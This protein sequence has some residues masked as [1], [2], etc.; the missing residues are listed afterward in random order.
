MDLNLEGKHVLVTG[1]TGGIGEAILSLLYEEGTKISFQY[2]KNEKKAHEIRNS[3]SNNRILGIQADLRKEIEV[4]KLF[5]KAVEKFGKID[6]L[7]ANAG[8]CFP[9]NVITSEMSLEQW[10]N[11]LKINL[12]GVFLCV[13]EF[14]KNLKAKPGKYG[15]LVLI[16]STAGKFGEAGYVDYSATKS[17]LM[18]GLTRTWKN[19]IVN[20]AKYGR[21]NTVSPGWVFTPMSEETLEDKNTVRKILQT[22]PL[23]KIAN[24]KDIAPIVVYL[25][26]DKVAGHLSGENIM[27]DGGMEG[28]ILFDPDE[29]KI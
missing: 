16:G 26:S 12:T 22:I 25:L 15:S 20:F 11:T 27:V 23:K 7:V 8:V 19:E 18:Y 9:E 1:G 3:Y 14:F 5:Q 24:V 28:R 17:A 6:G 13:R 2:L 29:I 4:S 21:V 10:E